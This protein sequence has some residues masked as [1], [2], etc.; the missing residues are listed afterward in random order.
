MTTPLLPADGL[1]P[2]P[3]VTLSD[4][5]R[6]DRNRTIVQD[7]VTSLAVVVG[8]FAAAGVIGALIWVNVTTLPG[9]TRVAAGGSM[10]EEQ[11]AKQFSI[12]GWFLVIAVVGGLLSGL[13][14]ML[15][16][17]G[18]PVIMVVL[19][20]LGGA[21]ATWLM[22]RCGLSWGPGNPNVALASA[23]VGQLVPIRLKPDAKGI[24]FAWSI[25][26]LIGAAVSLWI[27]ESRETRRARAQAVSQIYPYY[28]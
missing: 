1:P 19:L 25:A 24:Y 22:L 8:W 12:N 26:A 27:M 5:A 15:I 16:R 13:V 23:E 7:L 14:L 2:F 11:M 10:D 6:V 17:R 4:E 21:L 20:A 18:S 3:Q 28:G 9:Y